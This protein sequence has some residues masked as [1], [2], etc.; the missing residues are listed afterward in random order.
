DGTDFRLHVCVDLPDRRFSHAELTNKHGGESFTRFKVVENDIYVGDRAYG[1]PKGVGHVVSGGGIPLVRITTSGLPLS[2]ADGERIDLLGVAR[3]LQPGQMLDLDASAKTPQVGAVAGRLC[4]YALS[5]EDARRAERRVQRCANRKR[6]RPAGVRAVEASR[7]IFIFTTAPRSLMSVGQ[8]FACYRLRWQVEL[9]FKLMKT[10]LH[11]GK[12]PNH[13]DDT[14]RTWLLAKLINALLLDRLAR[15]DQRAFPPAKSP[16]DAAANR[17][18][19]P[20]RVVAF[21]RV[22]LATALLGDASLTERA[23]VLRD[24]Q[25]LPRLANGRPARQIEAFV[26]QRP[27][28]AERLG[29]IEDARHVG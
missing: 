8:V 16:P 9:A 6:G 5:E 13:R 12:L 24:P 25:A 10:V 29:F 23:R 28:L 7:Y 2:T 17:L 20:H 27:S 21:L 26:A 1:T 11:F 4:I 15:A 3:S 19:S 18:R 14:A 22:A